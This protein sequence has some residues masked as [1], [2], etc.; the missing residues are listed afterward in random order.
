MD[1]HEISAPFETSR[2]MEMFQSLLACEMITETVL[3]Y[4]HTRQQKRSLRHAIKHE[5]EEIEEEMAPLS[6]KNLEIRRDLV[7]LKSRA[8]TSQWKLGQMAEAQTLRAGEVKSQIAK[9]SPLFLA[10]KS[11]LESMAASS[12]S[13]GKQLSSFGVTELSHRAVRH[14]SSYADQL[15]RVNPSERLQLDLM[16]H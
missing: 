4:Q 14:W 3:S 11:E 7:R 13:L 10:T 2:V 12:T 6:Q 8:D 15:K 9:G 1:K 5:Q 16:A